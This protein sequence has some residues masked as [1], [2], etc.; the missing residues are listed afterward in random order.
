MDPPWGS[1]H[2]AR[3]SEISTAEARGDYEASGLL[4]GEF[5][6]ADQLRDFHLVELVP[7]R[8]PG[9]LCLRGSRQVPPRP[10]ALGAA[11]P[12][13]GRASGCWGGGARGAQDA[14]GRRGPRGG[15]LW[16]RGVRAARR[17]GES[18]SEDDDEHGGLRQVDRELIR[19]GRLARRKPPRAA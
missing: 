2:G 1:Y 19:G 4:A 14:G 3:A 9:P 10:Q 18:R 12:A 11:P 5:R 7:A 16:G 15:S 6:L 13:R 17:I 8:A